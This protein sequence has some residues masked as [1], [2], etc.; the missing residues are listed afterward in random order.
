MGLME[1]LEKGACMDMEKGVFKVEHSDHRELRIGAEVMLVNAADSLRQPYGF[2]SLGGET[3]KCARDILNSAIDLILDGVNKIHNM[4]ESM[5]AD[6][7]A[8][9]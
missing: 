3:G 8:N 7:T 1:A 6:V 4:P 9:I 5:P 2:C